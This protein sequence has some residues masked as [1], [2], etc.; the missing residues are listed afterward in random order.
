MRG[1]GAAATNQSLTPG[2][3][4]ADEIVSTQ[5]LSVLRALGADLRVIDWIPRTRYTEGIPGGKESFWGY[6]LNRLVCVCGVWGGKW[7]RAPIP[8]IPPPLPSPPLRIFNMT[9]F[10]KII[11]IDTDTMALKAGLKGR[12]DTFPA[13]SSWSRMR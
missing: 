12:E 3:T 13:P 6:S 5:Y 1:R 7:G 4:A 9:E 11:Y 8:H 10:K 2:R